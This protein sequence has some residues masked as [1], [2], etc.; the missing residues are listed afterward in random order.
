[1]QS[2]RRLK[3][4]KKRKIAHFPLSFIPFAGTLILQL[5]KN[6]KISFYLRRSIV[7]RFCNKLNYLSLAVIEHAFDYVD[8]TGCS[9]KKMSGD[10]YSERPLFGGAIS[11]SFPHRF[12]VSLIKL[13][14]LLY[15]LFSCL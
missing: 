2:L 15:Q 14:M 9:V 1:M 6:K 10:L 13:N 12:Q 5:I 7:S 4:K 11:S 3:N 8:V